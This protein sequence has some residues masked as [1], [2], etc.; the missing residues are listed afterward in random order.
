MTLVPKLLGL[1]KLYNRPFSCGKAGISLFI[2]ALVHVK[3][4]EVASHGIV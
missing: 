1:G 4:A 2:F 3:V